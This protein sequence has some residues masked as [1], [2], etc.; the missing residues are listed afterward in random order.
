[1]KTMLIG[2]MFLW[3]IS[4]AKEIQ[5]GKEDGAGIQWVKGL[6]WDQIKEKA[7]KENKYIFVD[8]YTTW[9][10]PCKRMDDEVYV[11]DSIGNFM[12]TKFISVRVQMDRTKNDDAEIRKWYQEAAKMQ[13]QYK[14]TVY[15]SYLFFDPQ[16]QIIHRD[17]SFAAPDKFLAMA[18]KAFDPK[19][20]YYALKAEYESGQKNYTLVRYLV[21]K[22]EK[23]R[24]HEFVSRVKSDYLKYLLKQPQSVIYTKDNIEFIASA[25]P[26]T[27]SPWFKI[28]YKTGKRI[29]D[30]MG[31]SSFARRAVDSAIARE[32][33][34]PFY[35]LRSERTPNWDS[36][37]ANIEMDFGIKYA[38]R[39][40]T[41]KKM[42]WYRVRNIKDKYMQNFIEFVEMD[43]MDTFY[44]QSDIEINSFAYFEVLKADSVELALYPQIENTTIQM[45]EGVVRRAGTII[46]T[47][48]E[49]DPKKDTAFSLRWRAMKIDTY[50]RLLFKKNRKKEAIQW[51]EEALRIS[52]VMR[53]TRNS[54]RF[55]KVLQA[56]KEDRM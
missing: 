20:Q 52:E 10:G 48:N 46:Y 47:L 1:M 17:V 8:C 39:N 3:S 27:K 44:L 53:D 23:F 45:M 14:V 28:F 12:N 55:R 36:M 37:Y 50:A 19:S 41:W 6:S 5:N 35:I 30:L 31:Q 40:I 38:N 16:G 18:S 56:M 42:L 11:K 21:T 26:D 51:Q 2:L 32:Y 29:N 15:P 34:N 7:K 4:N 43:G 25:M 9:C 49:G 33:I 22:G 24:D 54:I 13:E